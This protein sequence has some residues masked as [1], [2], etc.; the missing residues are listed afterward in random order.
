MKEEMQRWRFWIQE[1]VTEMGKGSGRAGFCF[2]LGGG[3]QEFGFEPVKCQPKGP[4][5]RGR[6]VYRPEENCEDCPAGQALRTGVTSTHSVR[7][8]E[9]VP[10]FPSGPALGLSEDF[11]IFE[12]GAC[13]FIWLCA[14]LIT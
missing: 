6:P 13:A 5:E 2:F 7:H 9:R 1:M 11:L 8:L 3:G 10:S 4:V 12:P 14:L